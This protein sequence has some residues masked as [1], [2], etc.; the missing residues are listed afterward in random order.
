MGSSVEVSQVTPRKWS[1]KLTRQPASLEEAG[2]Q[3]PA[4]HDAAPWGRAWA[5][6]G[7]GVSRVGPGLGLWGSTRRGHRRRRGAA[8]PTWVRARARMRVKV[9]VRIGAQPKCVAPGVPRYA[10]RKARPRRVRGASCPAP[11]V[12]TVRRRLVCV[13]RTYGTQALGGRTCQLR[14]AQ[15]RGGSTLVRVRVRGRP[16]AR[17]RVRV[18]VRAGVGVGDRVGASVSSSGVPRRRSRRPLRALRARA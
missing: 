8:A 10:V 11:W 18:R 17:V 14:R 1:R 16:R 9:R 5:R 7:V 6:V 12:R 4:P 3:R 13:G 2:E 15:P